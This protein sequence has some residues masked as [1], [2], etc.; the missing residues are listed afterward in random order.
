MRVLIAEDDQISAR[1][2]EA[3]LRKWEYE[4]VLAQDGAEAWNILEADDGPQLAILDWVMPVMNGI[5]V[6]CKVRRRTAGRYTYIILLTGN[7]DPSA[8]VEGIEAGADDYIKKPFNPDELQARLRSGRRI[9]ELQE[10]LRFQATRDGLT[11]LLN[12][13]A[14]LERL[15]IELERAGRESAPLSVA[16][17]DLDHFKTINDTYGHLTGDSVLHEIAIRML[18]CLRP[19]DL[20]GRYGG[21]E[22]LVILPNCNVSE[23]VSIADRLRICIGAAEIKVGESSLPVRASIGV[24]AVTGSKEIDPL[25]RAADAALYQAKHSGRNRV[26]YFHS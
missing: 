11:G 21:E 2:L 4:V 14:I 7:T 8:V 6:C 5:E 26:E 12:R 18:A 16:M 23:A 22:F 9:V 24:A 10:E 15:R 3:A 25:I 17:L 20:I 1:I 13:T 19:Y